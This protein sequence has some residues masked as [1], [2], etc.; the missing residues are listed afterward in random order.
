[1]PTLHH[2]SSL[3]K[4]LMS[5]FHKGSFKLPKM[6]HLKGPSKAPLYCP[7]HNYL[8]LLAEKVILT[9]CD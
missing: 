6:F 8:L 2:S 1:M 3:G 5:V 9:I 4:V 7:G